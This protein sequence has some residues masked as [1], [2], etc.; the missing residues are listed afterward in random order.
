MRAVKLL[1]IAAIHAAAVYAIV[2]TSYLPWRRNVMVKW[3]EKATVAS[4]DDADAQRVAIRA[5]RNLEIIARDPGA[6]SDLDLLMDAAANERLLGRNDAAAAKYRK[7]LAINR[8]PEI[9]FNL[10][11]T[12]LDGGH[13]EEGIQNLVT[14][15][16][17]KPDAGYLPDPAI[18]AEV[19]RRIYA[20]RFR[21]P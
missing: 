12:L 16:R 17:F 9:F 18:N 14:A 4:F 10:G 5:R 1:L 11:M 8:R 6:E 7:A 21:E 15:I 2:R 3:V 19:H 13:R 20:S